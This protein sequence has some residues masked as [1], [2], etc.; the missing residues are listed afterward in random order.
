MSNNSLLILKD[1]DD[2]KYNVLVPVQTMQD[3]PDIY[4]MA[5]NTVKIDMISDVYVMEKEYSK[6][7]NQFVPKNY[8]LTKLGLEKLMT[9]ANIK[10]VESKMI[11]P[12][13]VRNAIEMAKQLN[14]VVDFDK[15]DIG[16]QVVLSVPD[17]TGSER[18][19]KASKEMI[20]DEILE[21]CRDNKK[22]YQVYKNGQKKDA[23][24][25]EKEAAAQKEFKQIM[26]HRIAQAESKALNRAL[27]K[28]LMIKNK[29]TA[30]ELSKP[31]AVP[32]VVP[33]LDNPDMKKA[34]IEK[35][36]ISSNL[37]FNSNSNDLLQ[38]EDNEE[39][40]AIPE[41]IE[42]TKPLLTENIT[43][44]E[45]IDIG[46]E[47]CEECEKTITKHINNNGTEWSVDKIINLSKEHYG[48]QLC[49]QCIMKKQK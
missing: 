9:A 38:L 46:T 40:Q 15:R 23:T 8:A 4:K 22:N 31:F 41:V 25:T 16:W 45:N 36:K 44:V 3:F 1:Y 10:I 6:A 11:I 18:L 48:K 20:A 12:S 19:V 21:E 43:E 7:K 49:A 26:K 5:I 30:Q 24:K 37:L 28:A 27:R 32:I 34:C 47:T 17:M 29:Y 42:E 35:Y 14:Q 39:V 33:N 2:K 13:T